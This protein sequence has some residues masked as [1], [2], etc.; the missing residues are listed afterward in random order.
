MADRSILYRLRAALQGG[1][2]AVA[3]EV[4]LQ[5]SYPGVVSGATDVETGLQ[6]LD[7]TGVGSSIFPFQGSYTAQNSNISEWF[8]NR[9]QTRLRCTSNGGL[10]PVIFTL[11]GTTALNAAFDILVAAELPETIRFIIEY[12]GTSATFLRI[13]PRAGGPVIQGAS[14]IIVRTGIAATVEITRESGT[15][16]SYVFQAIGGIGDTG[17]GTL[18]S[19]KLI[20]P[21]AQIW[22][23]SS[24]GTLPSTGVVKGNA[25]KVV[26]APSDGSGRFGEVMQNADWVVWEGDSFTSWDAEPH[27]WFVIPGHEVRRITALEKDFITDVV[28]TPVS[29]RNTA[30]RGADYADSAGEIRLKIYPTRAGYDPADLNTSGLIDEYTNPSDLTGYLGIRLQGTQSTLT[31][32][33]PTL[34]I[35]VEDSSGNFVQSLNLDR[36]FTHEGDYGGE[37]DYLSSESIEYET[38]T[39]IRIY[40]SETLDRFTHPNLDIFYTNLSTALQGEVSSRAPWASIADVLFSGAT[41]KDVHIGDRVEYSPGYNKGV[42]WRDMSESTTI[43]DNRY[44]DGDLSITVSGVAF[45]INGFGNNLDKLVGIRLQRNDAQTGTGAMIE[46]GDGEAFVRVNTSNQVQV[47]TAVGTG[48]GNE[49]WQSLNDEN[50]NI[51]LANG[52]DNFL[53]FELVPIEGSTR[54]AWELVGEFFDGTNYHELNNLTYVPTG[55]ATGDNLGFARSIHQRG[56]ILDFRAINSPGYL[57]HSQL[58]TLL[59]QHQN[60][61]WDFGFARLFEGSDDREVVFQTLISTPNTIEGT[62]APTITPK[63]IGD[64][65]IDTANKKVYISVGTDTDGDWELMN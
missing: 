7:G 57:L 10:L 13:I 64:K 63:N 4:E 55:E 43:N 8:G 47:N 65:F 20:S 14:A 52:S 50:G 54:G 37:S 1:K 22:D 12:T 31:N 36:D 53:L 59:R 49:V 29:D 11:P 44:I 26:N 35:W 38:G 51:T 27:L 16:S 15:I 30:V 24:S 46:M 25:Y 3:K 17:G 45:T 61:K 41:V 2:V 62:A 48:F 6:K 33:L 58:D 39:T 34:Y 28:V 23:A 9:Q 5:E 19:I 42:D 60:D 32:V 18:D 56:Q 40:I 21:T